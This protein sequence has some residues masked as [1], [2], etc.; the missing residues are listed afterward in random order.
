MEAEWKVNE[1]NFISKSKWTPFVGRT[2]KGCVCRVVLRG[3]VAYV[4][5][6]VLVPPG[7]GIDVREYQLSR[8]VGFFMR[9]FQ[10]ER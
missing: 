8:Q 5:G 2:M 4:D 6:Q 7:Y 10:S 1:D 3:E 9:L